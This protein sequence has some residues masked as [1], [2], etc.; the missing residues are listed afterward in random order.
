MAWIETREQCGRTT[1][2]VL[3]REQGERQQ[4]TFDDQEAAEEF[5][6]HVVASGN[7]WPRGWVKGHGWEDEAGPDT[8]TFRQF[9]QRTIAARGKADPRTQADYLAQLERHVYPVIGDRPIERITRFDVAE[10]AQRMTAAGRAPKT[11]AN[12]HALMSSVLRDAVTD[13]LIRRNPAVGALP[14]L[15]GVKTEEMVFLTP[16]EVALVIGHIPSGAPRDLARTLYGTGARWSEA[17]AL[18]RC[19]YD[20]L[21]RK[22]VDI[23]RAWKRRGGRFELGSP[24]TRRSRRSVSISAELVDLSIPYL[25]GEPTGFV[26]TTENGYPVRHSNYYNR[27]WLPA[28]ARAQADGLDKRPGLHSLRHSHASMLIAAGVSLVAI[29]RRLGHESIQ[30]TIDRYGHLMPDH[31]VEINVAVDQSLAAR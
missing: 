29:Q 18:Q 8:V 13:E 30:T 7:R 12:V 2:R 14:V 22:A 1:W 17:T 20:V 19:D 26:F 3:W 25:V 10:V 4:Q 15:P 31:A 5:C 24:K 23:R 16:Q 6:G 28:V 27:I 21:E 11:V 9:A